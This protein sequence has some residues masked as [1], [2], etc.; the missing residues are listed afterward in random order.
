MKTVSNGNW[1]LRVTVAICLSI[2]LDGRHSVDRIAQRQHPRPKRAIHFESFAVDVNQM[3]DK[4]R[5]CR[6]IRR[7]HTAEMLSCNYKDESV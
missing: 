6:F 2:R 3:A 5:V 4:G 7:E 1:M